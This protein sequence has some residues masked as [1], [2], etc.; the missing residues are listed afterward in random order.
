MFCFSKYMFK[1]I[2]Y[3]LILNGRKICYMF[4][5]KKDIFL[6][7]IIYWYNEIKI[8]YK[9]LKLYVYFIMNLF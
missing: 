9:Y 2:I 5:F 4:Y 8:F 7:V 1:I 6:K 3:L